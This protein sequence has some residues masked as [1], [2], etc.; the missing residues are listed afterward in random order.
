MPT[1][2]PIYR[3][4]YA[5]N[6]LPGYLVSIDEPLEQEVSTSKII[7]RDGGLM[8]PAGAGLRSIRLGFRVLSQLS[9]GSGLDHLNDLLAQY[10]EALAYVSRATSLQPLYIGDT[11]RYINA[12]YARASQ[13]LTAQDQRAASYSIEFLAEPFFN[14]AGSYQ[15]TFSGNGSPSIALP[16]CRRS[17]PTFSVP[18]GVDGFTA[19]HAA[20]NKT[21]TF[22]R[23]GGNTIT[24]DCG[25]LT[26]VRST[27]ANAIATI[28]TLDFG[29]YH[30]GGAGNFGLTVSGFAGSGTVTV[31]I[32]PRIE[33]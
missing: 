14:L 9:S 29:M 21:L 8:Y 16:E 15:A 7:G 32:V 28:T 20:S 27:G 4:S 24:I 12:F 3:V 10:R 19:T 25:R 6:Y 22:L 18:P 33:R 30:A 13:P 26:A 1:P 11:D 5:G 17:Y 23:T 2:T 31:S